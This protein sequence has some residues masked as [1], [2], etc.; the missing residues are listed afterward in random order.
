MR[1]VVFILMI[2]GLVGCN[3]S[4]YNLSDLKHDK[5][6]FNN[7]P[8]DIILYLKN[9]GEYQIDIQ[10]M[11]VELPK[12][13]KSNY[14]LETVNTL[15]GPWVAYEKLVDKEKN[16]YYKIEQGV[17]SPYIVFENKLYIP[18]RFNILTAVED[19]NKVEFSCYILK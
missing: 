9:P 5:L 15:I 18:D 19:I 16:I 3:K 1:S 11:L 14:H 8:Q 17:P 13:K 6:N 2:F 10:N 12:N 4:Y 7:L